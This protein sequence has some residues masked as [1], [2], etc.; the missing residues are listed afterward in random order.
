MSSEE[1][2]ETKFEHS[3]IKK[4]S[5]LNGKWYCV[6]E[7]KY[8][9]QSTQKAFNKT[10][11][12]RD[13]ATKQEAVQ[14]AFEYQCEKDG[15]NPLTRKPPDTPE[16]AAAAAAAPARGRPTKTATEILHADVEED[17]AE[18]HRLMYDFDKFGL[19]RMTVSSN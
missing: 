18:V 14:A 9:G 6:I 17:E 4:I 5:E 19:Q 7:W 3:R 11:T 12:I 1:V 2:I 16:R 8:R 15:I 13:F 10:A